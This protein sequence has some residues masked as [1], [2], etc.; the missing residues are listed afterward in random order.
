MICRP[1]EGNFGYCGAM[2][3]SF[4]MG[5]CFILSCSP[6]IPAPSAE[7]PTGGDQACETAPVVR[8]CI[9]AATGGL[10]NTLELCERAWHDTG[11]EAVAVNAA[12]YALQYGR[13]D[14][15]R[16]WGERAK[17]TIEG[18]RVLHYWAEVQRVR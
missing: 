8:S 14:A 6:R 9:A 5:A 3:W 11:S 16:D 15:I 17:P 7:C 12:S 18:A 13:Y 2:R 4:W 1:L 10:P